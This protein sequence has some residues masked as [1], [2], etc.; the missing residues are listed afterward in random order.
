MIRT[1]KYLPA[2]IAISFSGTILIK[3]S[4]P[5]NHNIEIGIVIVHRKNTIRCKFSP[6]NFFFPLPYA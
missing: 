3:I 6:T 2:K 4:V 1:F 5:K